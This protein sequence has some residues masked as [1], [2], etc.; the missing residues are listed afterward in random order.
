MSSYVIMIAE[1]IFPFGGAPPADWARKREE[2]MDILE[3]TLN[4]YPFLV[5]LRPHIPSGMQAE[6]ATT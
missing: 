5:R 1:G 3:G 6:V 2:G 4:P